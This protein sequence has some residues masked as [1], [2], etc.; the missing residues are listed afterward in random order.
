MARVR[1]NIEGWYN[2]SMD[3]VSSWYKRRAQVTILILGLF[4][5][6]TVNV[7]T[8]TIAKRLS[9]DKALRESLI[10]AADAYAK[11]NAPAPAAGVSP[12]ASPSPATA[13]TPRQSSSSPI[14]EPGGNPPGAVANTPARTLGTTPAEGA[15]PSPAAA[16]DVSPSGSPSDVVANVS[17][18]TLPAGCVKDVDS[19]DCKQALDL[20]KACEDPESTDCRRAKD[21]QEAC[22]IEDSP[23]CKYLPTSS[24]FR[25]WVCPLAGIPPLT[26]DEH[27]RVG[28]GSGTEVG[29]IRSIGTGLVGC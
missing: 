2:A 1:E 18:P 12:E 26:R 22:K 10:A 15:S 27:G 11:E 19:A 16:P 23:K 9:T 14:A 17:S 20:Q 6:I 7:D 28:I 8:I 29:G 13:T 3:R 24:R 25:P 4:I 21:L 5:A